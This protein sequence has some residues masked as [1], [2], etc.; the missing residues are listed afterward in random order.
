MLHEKVRKEYWG[1][2]TGE[3]LT[4]DD[5]LHERYRGIRPAI[6]YPSLPDHT[7]KKTLFEILDAE[8]QAEIELTENYMM[9]PQAAVSG[10]F[11]AHPESQYFNVQKISKDQ[12]QDYAVRCKISIEEAEK[13]LSQNLNYK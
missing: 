5:I 2:S 10:L 11:L 12:V 9:L 8:N 4:Q 3:K 1:Y 6:G 7:L 13:R